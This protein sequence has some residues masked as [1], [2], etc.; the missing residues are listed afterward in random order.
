MR[1]L[2][3]IY[4]L[5][6][7]ISLIYLIYL[8]IS[9]ISFSLY[10]KI[11]FFLTISLISFFLIDYNLS[12]GD[13]FSYRDLPIIFFLIIFFKYLSN[14]DKFY[15]PLLL[16]GFLSATSFFWS[17]DRALIINFL[18][19]FMF[20][21]MLLN[22][23]YDHIAIIILSIIFFWLFYYYYLGFEFNYFLNNTLSVL[24]NQ[25]YIHGI[26]HPTPFSNMD[27]SSR[28]T[29][30]LLLIILSLLISSSFF[31][32]KRKDIKIFLNLF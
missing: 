22:K 7:K 30:S 19:I 25:N 23:R 14:M 6:F 9:N 10:G 17:I 15:F 12:T 4:I 31:S 13:S 1:Y 29:K 16:I 18:I 26:V 2:E 20:I 3:I 21:N 5:I 27:N 24:R 8:I 32:Q 28:A 11:A